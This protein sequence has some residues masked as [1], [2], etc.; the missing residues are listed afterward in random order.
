[1]NLFRLQQTSFQADHSSLRHE[2]GYSIII[3]FLNPG[4]PE[5]GILQGSV[6]SGQL[7][8]YKESQT[9]NVGC[10][11]V[12]VGE[13][14]RGLVLANPKWGTPGSTPHNPSLL[15]IVLSAYRRPR[16][17]RR[18]PCRINPPMT[19]IDCEFLLFFVH[20]SLSAPNPWMRVDTLS[21]HTSRLLV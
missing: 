13:H 18:Q 11:C 16:P 5:Y 15:I 12:G 7:R 1:M 17:R 2:P 21:L 6:P 20:V 14:S 19:E 10:R 4:S 8:G 9:Q 3:K